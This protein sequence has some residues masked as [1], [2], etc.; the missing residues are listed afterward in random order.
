MRFI[1]GLILGLP[2]ALS[3]INSTHAQT[4]GT[5]ALTGRV[6]DSA[7][8]TVQRVRVTTTNNASGEV[9]TVVTNDDGNYSFPLLSPGSYDLRFEATGFKVHVKHGVVINVTETARFDTQLQTGELRELVVVTSEPELLQTESSTLGRVN[10]SKQI[11]SLPLV[12]RN[13]TELITHSPGISVNV[14]N[15]S[16]VGPGNG[17]YSRVTSR[18]R[19]K[20]RRQQLSV[21]WH[22]RE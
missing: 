9:R 20:R 8:D 4:A 16:D 14:N 21:G 19:S 18:Q 11:T 13:F 5:G 1:K 12:S 15:A 3:F 22:R 7:N 17:G 10:D 2:L 6:T